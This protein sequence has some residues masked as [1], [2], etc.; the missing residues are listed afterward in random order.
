MYETR[1][2]ELIFNVGSSDYFCSH[3]SSL[4]EDLK[5]ENIDDILLSFCLMIQNSKT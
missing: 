1:I 3:L 2:C 4:L 5:N